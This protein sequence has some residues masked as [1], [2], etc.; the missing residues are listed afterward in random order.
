VGEG[1]PRLI[2]SGLRAFYKV[3]ELV[4][5]NV[6]VLCNLKGKKVLLWPL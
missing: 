6:V 1:A 5:K 2:A 3:E 4:G